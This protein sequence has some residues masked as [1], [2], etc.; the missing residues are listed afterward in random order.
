MNQQK[1]QL[2]GYHSSFTWLALCHMERKIIS[3]DTRDMWFWLAYFTQTQFSVIITSSYTFRQ[4]SV[5][6]NTKQMQYRKIV[7][8][9]P[10]ALQKVNKIEARKASVQNSHRHKD[11]ACKQSERQNFIVFFL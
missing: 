7:F 10:A 5:Y 2:L 3:F 1:F 6:E 4:F 8:Y 9:F 11:G